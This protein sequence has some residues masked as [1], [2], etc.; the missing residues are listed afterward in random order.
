MDK[1]LF[2]V[3]SK[4]ELSNYEIENKILSYKN[5][6]SKNNNMILCNNIAYDYDELEQESGFDEDGIPDIFQYY[7]ID[8]YSAERLKEIDEIVFYHN[9]LDIYVLGVTH[10][11]TN[12]AY[13]ESGLEL[14]YNKE[15]D[16]Y[17]AYYRKQD[18][19]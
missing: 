4:D 10:F 14:E 3:F 1:I 6:F 7:I 5:L 2:G 17:Y 15:N 8:D 12:W 13:V 19:K 11:G 9:K 18:N 16:L